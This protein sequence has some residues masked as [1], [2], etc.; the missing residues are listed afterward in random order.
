ME[1]TV[2]QSDSSWSEDQIVPLLRRVSLFEGLP[3]EDLKRVAGIV[4]GTAVEAGEVLFE[5]GDEGDQ[6]FIVFTGAVEILKRKPNGEEERLAVR[7]NGDG[8]GEMA[9]L[10]DAPRSAT[11]RAEEHTQ[12]LTVGRDEFQELLG[13]D[14]LASRMMRIMSKALR[15]L[16]IRFAAQARAV[17]S[18]DGGRDI[19]KL[20]LTGLLPRS[21]PALKGA[22]V[23]AGTG[24]TLEGDGRTTWLTFP[25]GDAGTAFAVL[26]V[27]GH[28]LPAA[29]Y[30]AV[31]RAL[32]LGAAP[33]AR[34]PGQLLARA[35]EGMA[36]AGTNGVEQS[37]EMA[38]IV[39]QD[40]TVRW[41]SAGSVGG[42]FV[43][44]DGSMEELASHGPPLGVLP[45]F[46]YGV[47]TLELAAG[48]QVLVVSGASGG[49]LRGAAD[50]VA[51]R[52]SK[53]V[54]EVVGALHKA[55]QR[56]HDDEG[57]EVSAFLI[58]GS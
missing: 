21:V 47:R 57:L 36:G 33:D 49:L 2:S 23:A 1:G 42:A 4:S 18:D 54:G 27:T 41:A 35:N 20:I 53:D 24:L 15:A 44:R 14:T 7:R 13:G 8:F 6:F 12:L 40:R 17:R 58:R 45:G 50:L 29:H 48:D 31:A 16:D 38:L 5:E 25:M 26:Q 37:V 30:L 9:L 22:S 46:A 32:V 34:D 43:R 39:V 56:A 55:I 52:R 11:A 28:G 19:S 10:N 51:Q 3:D